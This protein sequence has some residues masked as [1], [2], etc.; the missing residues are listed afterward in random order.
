MFKLLNKS[1]GII[2]CDR[3]LTMVQCAALWTLYGQSDLAS[4]CAQRL[5]CLASS[6]SPSIP[7]A[8]AI[9]IQQFALRVSAIHC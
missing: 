4:L 2:G 1:E 5:L 8:L 6:S 9:L 7:I 3:E